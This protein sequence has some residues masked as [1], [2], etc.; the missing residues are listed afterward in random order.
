MGAT[1][2]ATSTRASS[3]PRHIQPLLN[4]IQKQRLSK[5]GIEAAEGGNGSS[6]R[7][8]C[9]CR[10]VEAGASLEHGVIPATKWHTIK[11]E[12]I[13]INEHEANCA[14]R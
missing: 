4:R 6:G 5:H 1:R 9:G 7:S 8:R 11:Y 13:R 12:G 10:A 14:S 3:R 2:F